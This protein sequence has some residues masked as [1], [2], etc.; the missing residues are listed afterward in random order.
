MTAQIIDL[1]RAK[2][3]VIL[4]PPRP[5]MKTLGDLTDEARESLARWRAIPPKYH[6]AF[7]NLAMRLVNDVEPHKVVALFWRDIA[8][9]ERTEGAS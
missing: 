4:P 8:A 2:R 3:R 1:P 9:A 7:H 6:R 5:P